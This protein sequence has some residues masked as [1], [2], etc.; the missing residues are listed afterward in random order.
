MCDPPQILEF[1]YSDSEQKRDIEISAIDL[2][3]KCLIKKTNNINTDRPLHTRQA[4]IQINLL[5]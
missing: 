2:H 4:D 5:I 3:L 1:Q